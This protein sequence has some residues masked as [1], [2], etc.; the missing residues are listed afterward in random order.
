MGKRLS[1]NVEIQRKGSEDKNSM[2]QQRQVKDGGGSS[3]G[4]RCV[5]KT[6]SKDVLKM[7]GGS[8][9]CITVMFLF[10]S[11]KVGSRILHSKWSLK[12]RLLNC[13]S[14][15]KTV[16]GLLGVPPRVSGGAWGIILE[17]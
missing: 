14:I 12:K 7:N 9:E 1:E 11:E 13:E 3:Q 4:G 6:I 8:T 16:D 5:K 10:M 2:I 15:K 17:L